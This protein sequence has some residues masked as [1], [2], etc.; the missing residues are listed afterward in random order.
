MREKLRQELG[1]WGFS[2]TEIDV[3]LAMLEIGEGVAS[4]VADRAGVSSRHVYRVAGRLEE[5]GFVDVDDY[6]SPTRLRARPPDAVD[7]VVE[8]S[9]ATM[10]EGIEALFAG[11]PDR[12]SNVDLLKRQPTVMSRARDLLTSAEDWAFVVAASDAV[13]HVADDLTDAVD[14]DVLVQFLT[15]EPPSTLRWELSELGTVVRTCPALPEFLEFAI[16]VDCFEGL[17]SSPTASDGDDQRYSPALYLTDETLTPRILSSLQGNEWR[18]GDERVAPSPVELP[19]STTVY[20]R[21]VIQAALHRRNGRDLVA[22]VDGHRVDGGESATVSG[23]VVAVR[24]GFV[25][26]YSKSFLFEES[27]VLETESGTASFGD[28][29]ASVEDYAAHHVRLEER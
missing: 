27:M 29:A 4:D 6:V 22:T 17:V 25:E 28:P 14:R 21:A 8:E 26:P 20:Q 18:L 12:P 5:R 3:Y 23:P 11:R 1:R 9:R 10:V 7:T 2:D 24:Q 15:D 16:V 13:D 19:F